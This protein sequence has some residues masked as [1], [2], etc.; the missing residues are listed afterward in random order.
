M[1][2]TKLG[3]P[4]VLCHLFKFSLLCNILSFFHICQL[5]KYCIKQNWDYLPQFW[6]IFLFHFPN[7]TLSPPFVPIW[8]L[9]KSCIKQNWDDLPTLYYLFWE[10]DDF[11]T[12][13]QFPKKNFYLFLYRTKLGCAN[14]DLCNLFS[15]PKHV[16]ITQ[17]WDN[18]MVRLFYIGH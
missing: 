1:Y 8:Y 6:I 5:L 10:M 3:I 13:K 17:N 2:E 16:F 14:P 11:K 12:A 9:L 7:Y 18:L 15:C 4:I